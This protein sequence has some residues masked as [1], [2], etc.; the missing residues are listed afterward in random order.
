M[1]IYTMCLWVAVKVTP[2][3]FKTGQGGGG[4]GGKRLPSGKIC[5]PEFVRKLITGDFS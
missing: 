3:K 2:Q 4:G 1:K 5:C